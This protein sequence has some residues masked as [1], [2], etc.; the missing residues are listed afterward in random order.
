MVDITHKIFS[1]RIAIAQ[2]IVC[3][4]SEETIT[5][6][7]EHRVPKGDVLSVARTAGLFAAKK[8]V[9]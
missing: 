3:V 7:K 8:Q 5:A 9:T 6:I 4:G 1:Q 2:A